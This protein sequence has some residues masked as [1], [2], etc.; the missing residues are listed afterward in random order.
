MD[1]DVH[2]ACA[3]VVPIDEA[4]GGGECALQRVLHGDEGVIVRL[5]VG[6]PLQNEDVLHN[7]LPRVWRWTKTPGHLLLDVE[8]MPLPGSDGQGLV[9]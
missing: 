8:Q 1:E 5:R 7:C 2:L 3:E 6:W 9:E 4:M